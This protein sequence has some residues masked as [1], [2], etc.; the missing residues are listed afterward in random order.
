MP[1]ET[2]PAGRALVLVAIKRADGSKVEALFSMKEESA[3]AIMDLTM[4]ACADCL[5]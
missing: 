5:E 3:Q 1:R 4:M 2:P